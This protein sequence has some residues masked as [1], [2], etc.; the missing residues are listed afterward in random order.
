MICIRE[1]NNIYFAKCLYEH[2]TEPLQKASIIVVCEPALED[3]QFLLTSLRSLPRSSAEADGNKL[4]NELFA[5]LPIFDITW[6]GV[7]II[8]ASGIVAL[9]RLPMKVY[10]ELG[11]NGLMVLLANLASLAITSLRTS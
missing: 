6:S 9:M 10:G 5:I 4:L 2:V 7:D 3:G 1:K 11:S 8:E